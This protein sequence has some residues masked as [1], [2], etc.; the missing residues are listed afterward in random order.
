MGVVK[1]PHPLKTPALV[2]DYWAS[3]LV[4][5]KGGWRLARGDS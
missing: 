5:C 2:A 4:T 3:T 1:A